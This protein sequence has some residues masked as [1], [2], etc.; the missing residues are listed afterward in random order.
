M[1]PQFQGANFGNPSHVSKTLQQHPKSLTHQNQSIRSSF[2]N[3]LVG[4]APANSNPGFGQDSIP[5]FNHL[6][7]VLNPSQSNQKVYENTLT[8]TPG[9]P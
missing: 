1:N 4:I 8:A 9:H 5:G 3:S 6:S 2:N 7:D